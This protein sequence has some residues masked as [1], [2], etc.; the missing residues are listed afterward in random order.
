MFVDVDAVPGSAASHKRKVAL[1]G[2]VGA[3]DHYRSALGGKLVIN[4]KVLDHCAGRDIQIESV[5]C[6]Q[7]LS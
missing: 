4:R 2:N 1:D 6:W 7:R 5:L 3:V